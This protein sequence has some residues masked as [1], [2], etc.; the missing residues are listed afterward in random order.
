MLKNNVIMKK[1]VLLLGALRLMTMPVFSQVGFSSK[2]K[3]PASQQSSPLPVN[4]VIDAL[5]SGTTAPQFMR[6]MPM[7][8]APQPAAEGV[9]LE[10]PSGEVMYRNARNGT[11]AFWTHD[12]LT[13]IRHAAEPLTE[14]AL[15]AGIYRWMTA[16]KEVLRLED[17]EAE[18]APVSVETDA[19]GKTHV[20]FRQYYRGVPLWGADC[21]VHLEGGR[22]YAFNGRYE[23]TPAGLNTVPVVSKTVAEQTVEYVL[24]GRK[25]PFASLPSFLV[26]LG[27]QRYRTEL[28]IYPDRKAPRLAWHITVRPNVRDR[29]EFF[30]DAHTG[31]VIHSYYN[32]HRDGPVTGS[33]T[34]LSGHSRTLHLYKVGSTYYMIDASR[35]MFN[36]GYPVP[37]NPKGAI[38]TLDAHNTALQNVGYVTSTS[39][40]GWN[41]T[42]VSAH[43]NGGTVYEYFRTTHSRNSIDGQGGN[44][45]G[46]INVTEQ[47]GSQMDNAFWNGMVMAYG[48]GNVAMTPLAEALDVAAHEMG[49]GVIEKTA[50]LIYQY[51][52]GAMNEH[53]ADV[54]GVCVDRDDWKMGEDIVKPA[55]FPSGAMRDFANPHN[56]C[57]AGQG[58]WQPAH[59]NEFVNTSQ[60]NGG[61]H[62]NSGIL[63]HAF[64]KFASVH[65]KSKGEKIWYRALTRYLT[66]RSEFM[67]LRNAAIQAAKDLY[68]NNS[69]EAQAV[70]Q[71]FADVGIGSASGGG[72]GGGGGRLQYPAIPGNDY[73]LAHA[74]DVSWGGNTL[75]FI[76]FVQGSNPAALTTT[77]AR[78]KASVIDG[79]A[80][81]LFV[82]SSTHE[83]HAIDLN[84]SNPNEVVLSALGNTWS[85]VAVSPDGNRIALVSIYE[86][87]SIYVVDVSGNT[88]RTARFKLYQPDYSGTG[89]T[90]TVR[91][92]DVIQWDLSGQYLLFDKFVSIPGSQ[93]LNQWDIGFIHVWDAAGNDWGTG[94]IMNLYSNLPSEISIGNPSFAENTPDVIAFDLY[95]SQTDEFKI[96]VADLGWNQTAELF[97]QSMLGIPSF[98]RADNGVVFTALSTTGDTVSAY[99]P[100]SDYTSPQGNAS[101]L[102][103][104]AIWID[105]FGVGQRPG[106]PSVGLK[107]R[108]LKA[109]G[110]AV[111]YPNPA[112]GDV[113][114][115]WPSEAGRRLRV[116]IYSAR[117]RVVWQGVLPRTAG[118]ETTLP[119]AP[120][121]SGAY[122]V[123]LTDEKGRQWRAS[124]IKR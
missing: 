110:D 34:D 43:Y 116:R 65:G 51:Q 72:G 119:T 101:L 12:T 99:I 90:Y 2:T 75:Y 39:A 123:R 26:G 88:P 4:Q 89:G 22:M 25:V 81:A 28:V 106:G 124:L 31:E 113:Q 111:V 63:N 7:A 102:L 46:V 108:L 33:G 58:C 1:I 40:S 85:T 92:A 93:S 70:Q 62:I 41:A 44:I 5:A 57:S 8:Y 112:F 16:H 20:R 95:N 29:Y 114:L 103:T 30:V 91:Y 32:T 104:G 77:L 3:L 69:T 73:A 68:G 53:M 76:E 42:A 74:A 18:L 36:N 117:G 15:L 14:T 67:D 94:T 45:I 105:A 78:R 21:Y 115:R 121:P 23:P 100:V 79:G 37:Q 97:T 17:P 55:Y 6:R 13:L 10:L 107:D 52:S 54:F 56:G 35:P 82:N 11:P 120:L 49:H 61:V 71:A 84:P 50:N 24:T 64:Y 60:D 87:S 83:V 19:L 96:M 86:D 38:M 48:N 80:A 122:R 9:A 118:G 98:L 27:M 59:M 47:D 66:R 109:F